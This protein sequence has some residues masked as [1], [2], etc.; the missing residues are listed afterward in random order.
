V[1]QDYPTPLGD[2]LGRFLRLL[3]APPVHTVATL[4]DRWPEVVGPLMASRSRPVEV[5]NGVLVIACEDPSWASQL[6]WMDQQVK[7]RCAQLFDGLAVT[8]IRVRVD[9]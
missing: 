9:R 5:R 1:N 3:G 2:G 4:N 6:G 8:R 7:Q